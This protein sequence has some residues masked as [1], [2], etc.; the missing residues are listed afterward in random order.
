MNFAQPLADALQGI[1]VVYR[2]GKLSVQASEHQCFRHA[3]DR[4]KNY[5]SKY[6]RIQY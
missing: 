2:Q 5:F 6:K 4:R 3:L 1:F